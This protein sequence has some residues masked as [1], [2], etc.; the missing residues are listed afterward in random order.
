MATTSAQVFAAQNSYFRRSGLTLAAIAALGFAAF[1]L[2]GIT[3]ITAMPMATHVHAAVM[4]LW[5]GVFAAQVT[6][7]TSGNIAVHRQLGRAGAALAILAVVTGIT[8][9]L[10]TFAAGRVPPIFPPGYFLMLGYANIAMFALFV[11]G[12]VMLRKRT[13]WHKRLMLGSMVMIYEPVLGRTLPFL[14]IPALGGPDAAFPAILANREAF[15]L[16]RFAVHIGIAVLLL[17]LDRRASGRV[18]PASLLI[19][20]GVAVIYAIANGVGLNVGITDYATG[21]MQADTTVPMPG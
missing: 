7:A 9:I 1:N 14:I 8:A 15:E 13:D 6:L 21:L 11:G 4:T 2:A 12:A 20:A 10:A 16:F 18:H 19:V 5:L 3:D 17:V